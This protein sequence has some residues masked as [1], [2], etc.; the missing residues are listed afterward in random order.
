LIV[1][2]DRPT[3]FKLRMMAGNHQM[4]R[5]DK[6]NIT[7]PSAAIER[8]LIDAVLDE[9]P[10]NQAIIISD[11]CKGSLTDTLLACVIEAA[12]DLGIR[13]VVDPKRVDFAAYSGA[14]F[15]T[16]NRAELHKS[17]GIACDTAENCR[18][19][20]HRASALTGAGILL[21]RS[22]QGMS[23]YP[24]DGDEIVL[25]TEALQVFD[26][27]GAGDS[28]VAAF[29]YAIAS[30]DSVQQALRLA[31]CVAG[32]VVAKVGTATASLA[33]VIAA[34]DRADSAALKT[35]GAVTCV[36]AIALRESWARKELRVGFTNGCYDLI[37]PGHV[38]LLREAARQCDR[39]IVGL[40]SDAS[41]RRLKGS[42]RPV[43]DE[44]ARAEVLAAIRHVDLVVVFDADT[45]QTLIEALRPDVLIKGSDYQEH[46]I[47]GAAFVKALGGNVVRVD[48]REGHS[49]TNIIARSL[50]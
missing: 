30:G 32:L 50:A 6:E 41:V 28:V 11:Y 14:D 15:I 10:G 29:G 4:L 23:F 44:Q 1:A 20:A 25:P 31:N 46:E 33:E 43:Q 40:N 7:C 47:V 36:E 26:V 16:P 22:E 38:T 24:L 19:A 27:S 2:N 17:T 12:R 37:H 39:L 34:L 3:T 18:N 42:R 48:L 21:T 49:T 9:L 8:Q 35:T 13:V 45:P 5:I